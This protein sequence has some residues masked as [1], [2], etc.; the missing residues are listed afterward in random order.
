MT[1]DTL[2]L[3]LDDDVSGEHIVRMNSFH[4]TSKN[5]LLQ[6]PWSTC[7]NVEQQKSYLL[8]VSEAT[9]ESGFYPF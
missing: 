4:G 1:V 5:A 3:S 8:T 7:F 2:N 6:C 9:I